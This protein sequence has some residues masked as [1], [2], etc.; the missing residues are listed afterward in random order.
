MD[1]YII[2]E[3]SEKVDDLQAK[4]DILIGIVNDLNI[5]VEQLTRSK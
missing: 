3:L 2:M 1:Q 4:I 5:K